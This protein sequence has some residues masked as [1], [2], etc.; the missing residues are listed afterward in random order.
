MRYKL[1]PLRF[2]S[3]LLTAFDSIKIQTIHIIVSWH[4]RCAAA[5]GGADQIRRATQPMLRLYFNYA[6]ILPR[7]SCPRSLSSTASAKHEV[8]DIYRAWNCL[9]QERC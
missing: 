4:Q 2:G 5:A 9:G 7:F 6:P 8:A 1:C 3:R